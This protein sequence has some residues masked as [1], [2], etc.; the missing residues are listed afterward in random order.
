M[1]RP[2]LVIAGP[3]ASGKSPLALA[4]ARD[5]GGTVI[6][7][8]S[9]Q[10]YRELAILT[11]RPGPEALALVPHRLYGVLPAAEPC[12]AALWRR[13]ALDEIRASHAEGRLPILAGGSGL[14]LAALMEG[15]A[16]VPE[17]PAAVRAETRALHRHLGGAKFRDQLRRRDPVSAARLDAGDTQRLVR[18]FEVVAATGQPL[19]D[20]QAE[21]R[22]SAAD[23]AADL[24]FLVLVLD[25]PR[26]PLYRAC[27]ARFQAMVEGGGLEEAAALDA[28]GLDPGLPAMKALGVP[29]LI[30]HLR[31]R[32]KLAE[33]VRRGRQATRRYAKRQT[34]WFRQRLGGARTFNAQYSESMLPEIFANIRPFLLTFGTRASR[35]GAP[36]KGRGAARSGS[37][38]P[39]RSEG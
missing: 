33:A 9:M 5:L 19:P 38:K 24:D 37:A 4:V 16:P 39:I 2:V 20:W 30:A 25:P 7:A 11:A 27:D 1:T 32:M 35:F 3:T 6:N 13:M 21:A 8:D 31:G 12:S 29:Q 28:L 23:D 15:L 10:V 26:E 17:I 14:Y 34:T 22:D 36:A 18:A